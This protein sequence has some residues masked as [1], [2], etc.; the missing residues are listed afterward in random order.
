MCACARAILRRL[1]VAASW[2]TQAVAVPVAVQGPV[3][4]Q[5]RQGRGM[6]GRGCT[7][8]NFES[9]PQGSQLHALKLPAHQSLR[10]CMHLHEQ[11]RRRS[12]FSTLDQGMRSCDR[13]QVPRQHGTP[14]TLTCCGDFLSGHAALRRTSWASADVQRLPNTQQAAPGLARWLRRRRVRRVHAA[15]HRSAVDWSL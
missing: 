6:R 4:K 3:E 1:S 7:P 11:E 10:V 2:H 13:L 12:W 5:K 14:A 8:C 15:A 9:L